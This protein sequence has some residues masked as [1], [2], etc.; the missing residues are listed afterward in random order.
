MP[1]KW[2]RR[3]LVLFAAIVGFLLGLLRPALTQGLLSP[4]GIVAGLGYF[5]LS[6]T[7][8]QEEDTKSESNERFN[9]W[10][11]LIQMLLYFII[12]G[13]VGSMIP[14]LLALREQQQSL[15]LIRILK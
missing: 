7:T 3:G 8:T 9:R 4:I 11:L 13:A 14:F 1:S 12:G 5:L 6:R 15:S 10:F 2:A